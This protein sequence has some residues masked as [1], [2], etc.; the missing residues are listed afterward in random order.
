MGEKL[1][2]VFFIIKKNYY[3]TLNDILKNANITER[4]RERQR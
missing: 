3:H 1:Y 2:K 4:E